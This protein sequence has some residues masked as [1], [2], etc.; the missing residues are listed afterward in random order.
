MASGES[1]GEAAAAAPPTAAELQYHLEEYKALRAEIAVAIRAQFDAYLYAL[2][3]NGG[4]MAW[5][6]THKAELMA[7][8]LAGQKLAALVP[9][10]VTLLAWVWTLFLGWH[11]HVIA[12]YLRRLET[13]IAAS[14]L[15]WETFLAQAARGAADTPRPRR[16]LLANLM[17]VLLL[18]GGIAFA[19]AL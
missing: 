15:G 6:L 13:R 2:V 8:G 11:L 18:V 7:Y 17:W 14:A 19:V 4:I 3:A 9:V 16:M 5:L 12:A 1:A 10:A